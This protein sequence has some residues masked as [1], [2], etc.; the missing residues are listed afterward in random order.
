MCCVLLPMLMRNVDYFC[1]N[2]HAQWLLGDVQAWVKKITG[3]DRRTSQG[4]T[5]IGYILYIIMVNIDPTRAYV[6]FYV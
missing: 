5:L 1:F 4:R 2:R 3:L 6:I